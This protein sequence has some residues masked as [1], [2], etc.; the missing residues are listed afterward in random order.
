MP[1]SRL[2]ATLMQLT[3]DLHNAARA[4]HGSPPVTWNPT[5]A[6]WAQRFADA[7]FWGHDVKGACFAGTW[8]AGHASQTPMQVPRAR[9]STGQEL[10]EKLSYH[11]VRAS[12]H[13][14]L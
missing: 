14:L 3:L 10:H 2:N 7:C 11:L 1:G 9:G 13:L 6:A 4:Q 5:A 12:P 8:R